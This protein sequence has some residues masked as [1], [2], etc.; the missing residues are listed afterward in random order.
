LANNG[1]STKMPIGERTEYYG[2]GTMKSNGSYEISFYTNCCTGGYCE[3][4]YYY[5]I[6]TWT[7]YHA[8][9]EI[10]ATGTYTNNFEKIDNSCKGGDKVMT[11]RISESW[12]F[13]DEQSNPV[14][15]TEEL[16]RRL[17]KDDFFFSY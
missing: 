8:N 13:Y 4:F 7:Y 2:D 11:N 5:K 10:E 3:I 9:E 1:K 6:G 12:A 16:T 14:E 17:E 15:P